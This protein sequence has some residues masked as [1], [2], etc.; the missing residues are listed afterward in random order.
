MSGGVFL[1]ERETLVGSRHPEF[2][3]T[4][5]FALH[6]R[7]S[8]KARQL[9]ARQLMARAA[10]HARQQ[11]VPLLLLAAGSPLAAGPGLRTPG[12]VPPAPSP[13]WQ[14]STAGGRR[15]DFGSGDEGE[16]SW[17]GVEKDRAELDGVSFVPGDFPTLHDAVERVLEKQSESVRG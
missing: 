4:L 8:C 1:G 16:E 11:L 17:R 13:P 7:A 12:G 6:R 15:H 10:R 5:F 14:R 2:V 3:H 9:Q